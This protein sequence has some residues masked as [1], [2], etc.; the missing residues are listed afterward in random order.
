MLKISPATVSRRAAAGGSLPPDA[1]ERV[2]GVAKLIGQVQ[3]MMEESGDPSRFDAAAWL[4]DWL[5]APLPAFGG[6]RPIDY[7]DTM[8]GQAMVSDTLAQMQSGAYA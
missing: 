8:E 7:M 3:S 5:K 6:A 1:S 2:I 4:A